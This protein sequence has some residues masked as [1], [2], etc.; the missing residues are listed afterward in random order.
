ME[1]FD[2]IELATPY[3]APV[4]RDRETGV[5]RDV[6]N[7]REHGFHSAPTTIIAVLR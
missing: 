1:L 5:H 7:C 6:E 4:P 2:Y 3:A